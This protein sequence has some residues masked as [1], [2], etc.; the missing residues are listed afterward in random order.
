M[1]ILS[2]SDT[3]GLHNRIP[4]DWFIEADVLVHSGDVSNMGY[5]Q[6]IKDFLS[7]FDKLNYKHKIFIA[8]NHDFGFQT[9]SEMIKQ[10]LLDYPSIKYLQDEELIIDEYKFYGSP[11]TPYFHNWAFNCARD[12][13]ESKTY[14]KPLIKEYWD[15][16]PLDTEILIT[17]GPPYGI[18]DFVPYNNGQF[19]GCKD[20]L[21]KIYQ[22]DKLKAH[23]F[24][25]IHYSYGTIIKNNIQFINA[26][27]CN[28]Q[29]QVIQKPILIEI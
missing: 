17:H 26:S 15:K 20:L 13:Q 6:E 23:I 2:L 9:N 28:E 10:M 1:K 5:I 24:G 21:D 19:V 11:Q 27:T 22:L 4:N 14:N 18:G 8:G 3:H 29:Y 7:W 25:H 16:I 12:S